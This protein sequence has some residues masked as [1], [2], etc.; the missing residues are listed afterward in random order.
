MID[1]STFDAVFDS[2]RVFRRLLEATASP[3]KLF[4]LPPFEDCSPTDSIARALLDHETTFH[5]V[6]ENEGNFTLATG[7]RY[8]PLHEADFVFVHEPGRVALDMKRGELEWPEL[9]ATAVYAV[10]RLSNF[11]PITLRL[12]GPGVSGERMLGIKGLPLSEVKAIRDSRA[13]YPLGV[14]VYLVDGAGQVCGLPRST[15]VEVV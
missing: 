14:D 2:Q 1:T 13:D 9:G 11:G 5:V 7:A 12:S 3:G 15:K 4:V 6:G 8:A 10:E